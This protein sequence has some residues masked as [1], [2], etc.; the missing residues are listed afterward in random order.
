MMT[1][2]EIYE[3]LWEA[4]ADSDKLEFLKD[5][6]RESIK[7]IDRNKHFRYDQLSFNREHLE[8][9]LKGLEKL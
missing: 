6:I 1:D 8:I 9:L 7:Y 5:Y 3:Q 2:K 4:Y